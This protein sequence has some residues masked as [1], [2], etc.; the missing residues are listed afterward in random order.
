M[1]LLKQLR[2]IEWIAS[3]W[4]MA[5]TS[6]WFWV[7]V[8]AVGTV[9]TAIGAIAYDWA[10]WINSYGPPGWIIA[11][12]VAVV[13]VS[14]I[15]GLAAW[16]IVQVRTLRRGQHNAQPMDETGRSAERERDLTETL[17]RVDRA[18]F[19]LLA[20]ATDEGT[21]RSLW[22]A[23]KT[24]PNEEEG[25]SEGAL[26]SIKSR[27][28][29]HEGETVAALNGTRWGLPLSAAMAEAERN[30]DSELRTAALP[31]GIHPMIYREY[32]IACRKRSALEA[33]LKSAIAESDSERDHLLGLLREQKS[34]HKTA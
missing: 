9:L 14:A 24:I 6:P 3:L 26:L 15:V 32:I 33:F 11:A 27:L 7:V 4:T 17:R 18:V 31:D 21:H 5:T 2:E 19:L 16:S 28:M 10:A 30:A 12:A 20:S 22:K 1:W 23:L 29:D 34:I 13:S 8:G 25:E